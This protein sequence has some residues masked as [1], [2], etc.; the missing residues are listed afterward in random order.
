[1]Q[2]KNRQNKGNNTLEDT[3][4]RRE[5]ISL[6][7]RKQVERGLW[8]PQHPALSVS[9]LSAGRGPGRAWQT[10]WTEEQLS[11]WGP[12]AARVHR[13]QYQ[14]ERIPKICRKLPWI[15][16]RG[17]VIHVRKPPEAGGGIIKK[18]QL[19]VPGA[20]ILTLC[21]SPA[22]RLK[23]LRVP[24]VPGRALRSVSSSRGTVSPWLNPVPDLLN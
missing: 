9:R 15:F 24:G 13:T 22:A 17:P 21:L 16:S 6:I 14:G 10:L 11:A 20:H 2:P 19:A 18:G 8:F 23:K 4:Q 5:V 3:G 1:M 7:D 12:K